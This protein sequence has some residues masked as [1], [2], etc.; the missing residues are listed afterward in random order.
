[1]TCKTYIRVLLIAFL[2]G[3]FGKV[4]AQTPI[5]GVINDYARIDSIVPTKDTL[6]LSSNAFLVAGDT[7]LVMQM[8]GAEPD[9]TNS[10]KENLGSIK[11]MNQAGKMEF[12]KLSKV[13]PDNKVLLGRPLMQTYDPSLA[14]QQLI[15]V[16]SFQQARVTSNLSA[17]AWDGSVG[18]V[19]A[20][21]V[22]DT[23]FLD[24]PIDVSGQGFKG[25]VPVFS[26]TT[27]RCA[28]DD[29][30]FFGRMM[31]SE[32]ETK[33]VGRKGEGVIETQIA[34]SKGMGR[35]GNAGGGGNGR[36]AGGGG[37]GNSGSGDN[38]LGPN[39][40]GCDIP[41]YAD[42]TYGLKGRNGQSTESGA[43]FYGNSD[44]TIFMG[45]GGGAGNFEA[46]FSATPGGDGGGIVIVLCDYLVG[47]GGNILAT[48]A[49]VETVATAGAGGGGGGGVIFLQAN[50]VSGNLLLDVSGGDGGN[51]EATA[52]VRPG[53]GGGG[54]G[55]AVLFSSSSKPEATDIDI[56]LG[57]TGY[58]VGE[59]PL[60]SAANPG[61]QKF[62]VI[63][64]LNGFLF[65][66]IEDVQVL[67]A[68][69]T[70]SVLKGTTPKGGDGP[71]TYNYEWQQRSTQGAWQ[72]A[73]GTIDQKNY[74]PP[75]LFDT[76]LYRR[77][78]TSGAYSDTSNVVEI[79]VQP[80]IE[81][82]TIEA[83]D[84]AC[85]GNPADTI[86]GT[87]IVVGGEGVDTYNYT[88]Q[89]SFDQANWTQVSGINDTV[90]VSQ[91]IEQDTYFRRSVSSGACADLSN[92]AEVKMFPLIDNNTL[93]IV[94]DTICEGQ[95]PAT[96][97]GSTP[98]DGYGAG[99]YSYAW[100]ESV[101]GSNWTVIENAESKDFTPNA[102]SETTLFR[103]AVFSG[104][105]VDYTEPI[106]I[107]VL[108]P[109]SNN[110]II[111]DPPLQVCYNT[112]PDIINGT[113]PMGGDGEYRY[114]W[115]QSAD[116]TNWNAL[117][118]ADEANYQPDALTVDTY[119]RRVAYSGENNCCE[120][121]SAPA[122]MEVLDLP[123]ASLAVY[124]TTICSNEIISVA[125]TIADGI[126]PYDLTLGNETD[127]F[128]VTIDNAG[129]AFVEVQPNTSLASDLKTYEVKQLVDANQCEAT[130]MTGAVTVTTKGIPQAN[131]GID[132][133][134]CNLQP[135]L[136]ATP[137]IGTGQW[138]YEGGLSVLIGNDTEASTLVDLPS[139]NKYRFKWVEQN[140]ACKD[141]AYVE[142]IAYEAHPYQ[143]LG[144]DTI[145]YFKDTISYE[146]DLP[147]QNDELYEVTFNWNVSEPLF[148]S[149]E[150]D[151]F[152]E[153]DVKYSDG[154]EEIQV[155]YNLQKGL[156]PVMSDSVLVHL[157]G[158]VPPTGFSPNG[159]NLNETLQIRG[160][161]N[162]TGAIFIYNR[163]GV[164][165]YG[166]SN[167][168]NS[169]GWD[170][171]DKNGNE[172]PEDTYYYIL[173]IIDDETG[174]QYSYKGYVVLKRQ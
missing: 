131:A 108:T 102:L 50:D 33:E 19:V 51:T 5:S 149:R 141:S 147:P 83:N 154:P 97:I 82:N 110:S 59:D 54:G 164:E 29:P 46:G 41:T 42:L 104:D 36:F 4:S 153:L 123:T 169:D 48:G 106:E 13:L 158:V 39:P 128:Q 3:V 85:F 79:V 140:W 103:R 10:N 34:N 9:L 88:W 111:Q 60:G 100:E 23:L 118:G 95:V 58:V 107:T 62:N 126:G 67:C 6:H 80:L 124:D 77:I 27:I 22:H 24:A 165:V 71:G 47:S 11:F 18:G 38:S 116:G 81:N 28:A 75:A 109:I 121:V 117:S 119:F 31:F 114:Q 91:P 65:N 134:A 76:T 99:T 32:S 45:G 8:K 125:V 78:V 30:D 74:A 63:P 167:Y 14:V 166:S 145:V 160:L 98:V 133:T 20:L 56:D 90:F 89:R 113:A 150:Q 163:W 26:S 40:I 37:G 7:V 138:Y 115:E 66:T 12:V 172:L 86:K 135:R 43:G 53:P 52:E 143:E 2:F 69:D 64:P 93:A 15:R 139:D 68:G 101:D 173:K 142:V 144:S 1:M 94:Q 84:S 35:W 16:P 132:F 57:Q 127:N 157:K 161:E 155:S 72:A 112:I 129:L 25:G 87:T 162:K 120:H 49:S 146:L 168:K 92:T 96:I 148:V 170:G 105:C 122:L 159:D 44:S 137:S 55:G 156:C 174:R 21:M 17:T 136:E 130:Q 152:V 70:P 151:G 171:R 73:T 61:T